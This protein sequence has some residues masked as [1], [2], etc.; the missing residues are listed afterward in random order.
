MTVSHRTHLGR[1]NVGNCCF[2]PI[3]TFRSR[4]YHIIQDMFYLRF[5]VYI[6]IA[7]NRMCTLCILF[8]ALTTL[9]SIMNYNDNGVAVI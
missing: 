9:N 5:L 7:S 3:V 6:E 8:S 1:S 4:C 2:L